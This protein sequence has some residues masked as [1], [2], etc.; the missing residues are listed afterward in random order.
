[1]VELRV[2][3][4]V[5]LRGQQGEDPAAILSHPKRLAV[6]SYLAL[7]ASET[8]VSRD[9]LLAIFWP[10]ADEGRARNALSQVLHALRTELGEGVL[11]SRGRREVG[12]SRDHFT[13]DAGAFLDAIRSGANETAL[14]LYSGHLLEGFHLGNSQGFDSWLSGERGRLREMAAR[15]AWAVAHDHL[16]AGAL[17]DAER[18]GQRALGLVCTDESEVRRFI[19]ALAL[20]GDRAGA[21]QFFE[22]FRQ[23]LGEEL[24]L[25]PSPR[26]LE[27]V[28]RVREAPEA[29]LSEDAPGEGSEPHRS[30]KLPGAGQGAHR[31]DAS[32]GR[33]GAAARPRASVP[34]TGEEDNADSPIEGSGARRR[35]GGRLLPWALAC[36]AGGW[37]ATEAATFMVA[38]FGWP[39]PVGQVVSLFI[40]LAAFGFF[41]ALILAFYFGEKV[42]GQAT[43][44]ELLVVAVVMLAVGSVLSRTH[45]ERAVQD[46]IGS[47]PDAAPEA[48]LLILPWN[49]VPGGE[50]DLSTYEGVRSELIER[51]SR[52]EWLLIV[53][54]EGGSLDSSGDRDPFAGEWEADYILHVGVIRE[55]DRLRFS[56]R[57]LAGDSDEPVWVQTVQRSWGPRWPR[58]WRRVSGRNYRG[59]DPELR[60]RPNGGSGPEPHRESLRRTECRVTVN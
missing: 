1:M 54:G 22:R 12:L 5:R 9:Q 20:A 3:G 51:L 38:R 30:G 33:A 18:T 32:D 11:L 25:E 48:T 26:T 45:T 37:A 53:R 27:L 34:D 46:L 17:V 60:P 23:R 36:L 8:F 52:E 16:Q 42:R 43:G 39:E 47:N 56:A 24:D 6:L 55:G 49:D 31:I 28:R 14:E 35:F 57:L 41:F 13:C 29:L 4:G 7:A 58:A 19:H 44:P 15:A 10:D 2:L 21:I 40:V 50:V 59:D